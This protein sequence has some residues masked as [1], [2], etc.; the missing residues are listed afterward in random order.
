[1]KHYRISLYCLLLIVQF[2]HVLFA[3][4]RIPWTSSRVVGSPDAPDAFVV[5]RILPAVEFKNPVDFA[6]EPGTNRWW[7]L[8]LDGKLFVVDP[9]KN[10]APELV[11][12]ARAEI[13]NHDRSYGLT[14]HP[15]YSSNRKIYL[16]YVVK[17]QLPD[18]THVSEFLVKGDDTRRIDSSTERLIITWPSGGHNGAC[19]KF[20]PDGYLYITAGDGTGPFPPDTA[21]AGQNLADLRSTIMRIDVDRPSHEKSYSIP[22]DNPFLDVPDARPEVWAFGFRNPW[23][24]SF[25]PHTGE[26]WCGDVGWELWELVFNVKRAGNYGWSIKEGSQPI[27]TDLKQ[28]PGPITPPVVQH[29]HTEAASITGGYIYRGD[30]YPELN[31]R[32]IYGDYVTGKI[33]ALKRE[34]QLN[35]VTEE[36]GDTSLAIITFGLDAKGELIVVDYAGGLY[37]LVPNKREDTSQQ[38][39]RLLSQTGLFKKVAPRL[40]NAPGVYSYN[41]AAQMWQDG[42][43]AEYVI[44]L[45]YETSI[46]APRQHHQWRYP[47]GTVFAK[48]IS[49]EVVE[50]D[51]IEQRKIETQLLHYDGTEWRPYTYL[52]NADQADAELVSANGNNIKLTVPSINS[53]GDTEQINWRV[54]SR[55]ECM[56][57]HSKTAGFVVGFDLPNLQIETAP[58]HNQL[59]EF[60]ALKLFEKEFPSHWRRIKYTQSEHDN[61]EQA[62]R[63]YLA[64]NCAHCHRRGGGGTAHIELPISHQLDQTR[65]I[66]AAPTQ[67][68]FGIGNARIIAPGDPS[69]SVLFYRMATVGRGHMPHLGANEVDQQGLRLIADWIESL[70]PSNAEQR[71]EFIGIESTL[72]STQRSLQTT[73]YLAELESADERREVARKLR[74]RS[75][76]HLRGLWERWL[77]QSE[78]QQTLGSQ[79]DP[80]LILSQTGNSSRGEELFHRA[81]GVSCR[82]CHQI[83]AKGK[84][85]GPDLSKIGTQRKPEEILLSIL[86]P[87]RTIDPKYSTRTIIHIDGRVFSGIVAEETGG[88]VTIID[89][90][91]KKTEFDFSQVEEML[92]QPR[93]L[94]PDLLVK[95]MTAQ[96]LADL[97]AYL[98]SLK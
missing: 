10:V 48:T 94:M 1:M 54:A 9:E 2:D 16:S 96:E 92:T 34:G 13:E 21:N 53:A 89:S 76:A 55:S 49:R 5:E 46:V 45:P 4:E 57:C 74:E 70:G 42:A 28:G 40:K 66:D 90:T 65:A 47:E 44:G 14:F 95:E 77:P 68:S 59:D 3:Q 98:V 83:N 26:L 8:Q 20:G 73:R 37:R 58:D 86:E 52:W 35:D 69:R 61:L 84:T 91:G 31:G 97:L 33:W 87:S 71:E 11:H 75:P 43:T 78:R 24:I 63:S 17:G 41:L 88:S 82:N 64:I 81:E 36:L 56:T 6:L 23:K 60:I 25:D 80:R 12:D 67:G 79:V 50:N 85:V 27:R 51:Q 32:Y 29:P 39:P 38:F 30:L 72:T 62:A 22:E 93:S 19:L 18:G 7:V 15:D